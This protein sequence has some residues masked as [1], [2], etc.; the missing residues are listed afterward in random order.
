M[1]LTGLTDVE[2]ESDLCA[3]FSLNNVAE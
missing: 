3:T 2:C 1:S